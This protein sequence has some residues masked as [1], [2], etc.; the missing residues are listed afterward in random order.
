MRSLKLTLV[1][2]FAAG[3]PVNASAPT[4]PVAPVRPVT[5]NY[6]GVEVADPYRWMEDRRS[7]EFLQYMTAQG[8]YARVILDRLPGHDR[9]QARIAAH[10]GG[11]VAVTEVQTAGERIF[12]LRRAPNENTFKL[13][14]HEKSGH[15]RLL[16][17]PDR[18]A[19]PGQHFAI[20]YYV[21]APQGDKLLYGISPGGS[22]QSVIHI[23]D[24][25]SAQES[26]ETCWWIRMQGTAWV[27]L[28]CSVTARL[29]T[30]WRSCI[31]R[32]AGPLTSRRPID[33]TAHTVR[34]RG[35]NHDPGRVADA[36][37]AAR[38]LGSGIQRG[39]LRAPL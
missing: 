14:V 10:T 33:R 9:L 16:I 26:P 28:N 21:P 17:D 38:L 5:E 19:E 11:G 36:F 27:R 8:A 37:D 34:S 2:I 39:K 24:V 1:L 20:G 6:F 7:P 3:I 18:Y 31:G 4:P 30:S 12:F 29:R 35:G 23:L 15:D 22:E 25:A 13:W 32:S